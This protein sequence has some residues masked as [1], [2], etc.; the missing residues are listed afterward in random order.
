MR[1]ACAFLTLLMFSCA[2]AT[3]EGTLTA[4]PYTKDEF[5]QWTRDLR[6]TEI[7]SL[8]SLPFVTIGTTLAYSL[9]QGIDRSA[10]PE[11]DQKNVLY[12]SLGI[13]LALGLT[14]L[15]INLINR[16]TGKNKTAVATGITVTEKAAPPSADKG[17]PDSPE[18]AGTP[19]AKESPIEAASPPIEAAPPPASP[20]QQQ[21]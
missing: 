7:I 16:Y 9:I 15:T 18:A 2:T 1:R 21:Q 6:R 10:L 20:P 17:K 14:D 13:S 11:E 12:L 3:Q 8:G 4:D 5:P 19:E